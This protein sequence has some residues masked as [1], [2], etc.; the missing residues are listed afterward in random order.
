MRECDKSVTF[1]LFLLRLKQ[2]CDYSECVDNSSDACLYYNN[3][4]FESEY[5][6]GRTK[7]A[8]KVDVSLF[9]LIPGA[10]KDVY[11]YIIYTYVCVRVQL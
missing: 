10:F 1:V 4:L 9:V 8:S 5:F 6:T 11:D 7:C 2:L 3:G